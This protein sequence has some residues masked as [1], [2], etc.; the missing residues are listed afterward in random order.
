MGHRPRTR[1]P[2]VVLTRQQKL[3]RL[4]DDAGQ[5]GG[6][7][8]DIG[9]EAPAIALAEGVRVNNGMRAS[10]W[11]GIGAGYN[12][13]AAECFLDEVAAAMG[14]DPLAVRLELTKYQP[15]ANAVIK[16]AAEM[17]DFAKKRPDRGMGIAFSDYHGTFTA[18]V[19]EVSLDQQS[20]KIKV[21]NYWIAVDP[22]IA[23]QPNHVHAQLESAVCFGL[24]AALLEELPFKNGAPQAS[25][26]ND[27]QVVRMADVPQIHTKIVASDASPTGIGEVGVPTVAPAIANAIAQLTGKRL[28]HLPMTPDRVKKSLG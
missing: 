14:K 11:R 8:R 6:L 20:G 22:G 7:D 5:Y 26:F 1:R 15:R 3:H 18:G 19:A 16:A 13:F 12:K 25:N 27:Y 24:S 28:R 21:H 10:P 9:C 17:S 23:V 4:L 2:Y